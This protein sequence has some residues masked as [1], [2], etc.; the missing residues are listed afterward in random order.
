M[1]LLLTSVDM[2]SSFFILF[3]NIIF[4][5]LGFIFYLAFGGNVLELGYS[6]VEKAFGSLCILTAF[7]FLADAIA[8]IIICKKTKFDK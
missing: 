8:T 6:D 7:L 1:R 5:L 2:S 3:Q 4:A